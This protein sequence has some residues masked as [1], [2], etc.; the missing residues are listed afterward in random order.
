MEY[1]DVYD[2][3]K[4]KIRIVPRGSKLLDGEFR[5]VVHICV[6]NSH[7]QMLIQK[8]VLSKKS[9]PGKWDISVGGTVQ[10]GETSSTAAGRELKEEIGIDFDF[11]NHRPFITSSFTGGFDDFY[12]IERD[13]EATSFKLQAEE[14]EK[15]MWADKKTV[16]SMIDSGE[17]I[18]YH[19]GFI[20]M[21]FDMRNDYGTI[22]G[23]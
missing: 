11:E 17:F 10:A 2:I 8:R 23:Y 19:K 16:L 13:K 20:E 1:I 7:N 12:L 3:H 22:I 5:L 21:L 18:T 4:N 15:V 6:F 9:F 14:V